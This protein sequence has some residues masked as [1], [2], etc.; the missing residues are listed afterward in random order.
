MKIKSPRKIAETYE[1]KRTP[2][3]FFLYFIE[4]RSACEKR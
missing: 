4:S 3:G 1:Q 2:K